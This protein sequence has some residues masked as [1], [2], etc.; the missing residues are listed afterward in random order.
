MTVYIYIYIEEKK[1][2]YCQLTIAATTLHKR[3]TE[4]KKKKITKKTTKKK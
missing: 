1:I 4:N 2:V 3:G